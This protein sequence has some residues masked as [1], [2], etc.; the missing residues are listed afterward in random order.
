MTNL[1]RA[2]NYNIGLDIGTGSVGWAVT[3]AEGNLYHFKGKPTWGSRV[4]PNAKTAAEAQGP[5]GQRRRYERR[6]Q[7]LNLLQGFF[8]EEIQ[9]VDPDFFVR[10]NHS[11]LVSDERDFHHPLFN[12]KDFTEQEYYRRFPTIYHLRSWLMTTDEQADIRLIY[13]ALHN[14]VKHRGNFLHQDNPSLSAKNANMAE[15]VEKFCYA[16]QE[17]CD[18]HEVSCSPDVDR[19]TSILEDAFLNK[20]TKQEQIV[21]CFGLDKAYSKTAKALSQAFVG[22]V[23]DY[24]QVYFEDLEEAKFALSNDEKTEAF[25]SVCPDEGLALLRPS[26]MC[27]RLS[28]C[29]AF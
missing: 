1:R 16:F 20:R 13:L 17:W 18:I 4:F 19:L 12:G 11:Y 26:G 9:K 28:Y 24:S 5:R 22:Y 29:Q 10:L 6:R 23:A 27:I 15:S 21:S 14:I 7:R 2:S 3:D 8:A 25:L